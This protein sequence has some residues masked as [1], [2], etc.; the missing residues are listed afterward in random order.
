MRMKETKNQ[1]NR[2][3]KAITSDGHDQDSSTSFDNDTEH[4][5]NQNDDEEEE[6]DWIEYINRKVQGSCR[7]MLAS[8]RIELD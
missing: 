5:S 4:E 6:E 1:R 3:A 8:Q 2:L 7:K